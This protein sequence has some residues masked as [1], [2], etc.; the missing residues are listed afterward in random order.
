MLTAL[1][2]IWVLLKRN[3]VV[4]VTV[5]R[6]FY[7]LNGTCYLYE[8]IS[9][10][11]SETSINHLNCFKSIDLLITNIE[12]KISYKCTNNTLNRP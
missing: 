5:K 8:H 4:P 7:L 2:L 3:Y 12:P 11:Y 1:P 6:N 9:E 10:W